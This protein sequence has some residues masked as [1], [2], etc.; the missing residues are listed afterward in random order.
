MVAPYPCGRPVPL[1]SPRTLVVAPHLCGRPVPLWSPRTFVDIPSSKPVRN[2]QFN[3]WSGFRTRPYEIIHIPCTCRGVRIRRGVPLWSPRTFVDIPSSK[4][5]RNLQFNRW[6]GFR[7][8]PYEIIHIPCTCRGVP[9][10]GAFGR[11]PLRYHGISHV[12]V[13]WHCEH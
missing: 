13:V 2:L 4:P 6:S 11:T 12:S 7:T 1:W 9:I 3:R 10:V 5:V 8:H